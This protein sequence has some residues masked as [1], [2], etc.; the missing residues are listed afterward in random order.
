MMS[1][2]TIELTGRSPQ[3]R[4]NW[5][6]TSWAIWTAV[7]LPLRRRRT[8]RR[9]QVRLLRALG[10]LLRGLRLALVGGALPRV[11][12]LPHVA[13]QIGAGQRRFRTH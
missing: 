12:A 3:R 11:D 13:K 5:R 10:G 8:N 4:T 2:R 7:R 1:R 6:S 9:E